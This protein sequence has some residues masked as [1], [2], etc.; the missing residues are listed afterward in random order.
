MRKMLS[1]LY[2]GE[3]KWWRTLTA[4]EKL[5]T[6]YFLASLMLVIGLAE[7]NPMWVILLAVLNF[8]NSARLIK[9]VPTDGLE[10]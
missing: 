2:S 5:Y 3:L 7:S 4:R 9:K 1:V 10:E 8:G 6:V